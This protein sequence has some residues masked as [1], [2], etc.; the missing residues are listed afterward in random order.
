[1]VWVSAGCGL[2]GCWGPLSPPPWLARGMWGW[3]DRVLRAGVTPMVP[4]AAVAC[5]RW[6]MVGGCRVNGAGGAG[7]VRG[8]GWDPAVLGLDGLVGAGMNRR[9]AEGCRGVTGGLGHPWAQSWTWL[10]LGGAGELWG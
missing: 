3:W 4:P 5:E 2:S 6:V 8:Q 7:L 1:M 9:W 10:M